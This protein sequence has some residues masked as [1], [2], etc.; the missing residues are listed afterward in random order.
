MKSTAHIALRGKKT[1]QNT[2]SMEK[3]FTVEKMI[4][5]FFLFFFYNMQKMPNCIR[6]FLVFCSIEV[7]I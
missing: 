5:C 7:V 2:S 4:D 6:T 1:E 3:K